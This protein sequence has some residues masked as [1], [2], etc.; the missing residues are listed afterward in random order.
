MKKIKYFA[1]MG[2]MDN[3]RDRK[4]K[5]LKQKCRRQKGRKNNAENVHIGRQRNTGE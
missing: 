2:S 1:G 3:N 5:Q 4:I